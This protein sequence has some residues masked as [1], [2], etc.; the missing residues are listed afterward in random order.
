MRTNV[1]KKLT[2]FLLLIFLGFSVTFLTDCKGHV[3]I[4]DITDSIQN[5]S[6]PFVVNF[7]PHAQYGNRDLE[8]TWDFGDGSAVSH[9]KE[10]VHIYTESK[11]YQVTLTIRQKEAMETK[12]MA[13]YLTPDSVAPYSDWDYASK[14]DSL[15][16]PAYVE[17]QNYSKHATNYYWQ[18]GDGETSIQRDP[19]HIYESQ[20][21][22]T[23]VLG[24]ICNTDTSK[25][26]RQ[27]VIK[28]V[29]TD[30]L[31]DQVTV[32]MPSQYIGTNIWVNIWYA[33]H[34]EDEGPVATAVSSFPITFNMTTN[35]YWFNGNYNSD[36]LEFEVWSSINNGDPEKIF[37][38]ESRDLQFEYYPNVIGYDDGY[39]F[40]Y[41][42]LLEYRN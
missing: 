20:G 22:Y 37:S 3:D 35:L 14:A 19:I 32:W 31:V 25:Y 5:C 29:P 10:P 38:V 26:S 18:F 15:W 39:G 41:E 9:D 23:T 30:I 40:K 34:L 6:P 28:P 42:A 24:A 27:M 7:Y 17:F 16:A 36:L 4:D 1:L 2:G 13:L 12:S 8:F 11:I 21:T 33:G